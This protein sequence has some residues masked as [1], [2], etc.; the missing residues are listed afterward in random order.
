MISSYVDTSQHLDYLSR[1]RVLPEGVSFLDLHLLRHE[2]KLDRDDCEGQSLH[3][4]EDFRCLES[5]TPFPEDEQIPEKSRCI[6]HL[7]ST[8]FDQ[9]TLLVHACSKEKRVEE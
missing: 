7:R 1:A 6:A 9:T 3:Q 8:L 4:L 2:E 5:P